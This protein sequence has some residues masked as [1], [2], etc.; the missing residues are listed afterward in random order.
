M[1][2]RMLILPLA[3]LVLAACGQGQRQSSAAQTSTTKFATA[4]TTKEAAVKPLGADDDAQIS[5]R[6]DVL[7][8][9][10]ED[11]VPGAKFPEFSPFSASAGL[12]TAITGD[13]G[14]YTLYLSTSA[15]ELTPHE[16]PLALHKATPTSTAAANEAYA[17]MG[18]QSLAGS[19]PQT[20]A[21]AIKAVVRRDKRATAVMWLHGKYSVTVRSTA[22]DLAAAKALAT[23]VEALLAQNPLP[24]T[25]THGAVVLTVESQQGRTNLVSWREASA[26]YKISGHKA[27][28]VLKLAI[29]IS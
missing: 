19:Q 17:K 6:L 7:K 22:H 26:Y 16:A 13:P 4:A 23:Q 27:M 29:A 28:T 8:D 11:Q 25:E 3:L 2:M 24:K 9:Y 1:R 15:Q 12:N 5:R 14:D 10:T 20:L 21:G 18:Y